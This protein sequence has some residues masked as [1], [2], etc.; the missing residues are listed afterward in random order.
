VIVA[1]TL[2]DAKIQAYLA[3]KEVVV[4]ATLNPD[5]SPLAMPMWFLHD[6]TGLTMLSVDGLQKVKNLRRDGR[7]AV[8]AESGTRADIRGVS[9]RGRVE[10]LGDT[11]ERAR[12]VERFHA[13]YQ[14]DLERLWR[15][16][17]MPGNRVMFR[18]VP[19]HV[20]AWGLG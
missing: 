14:P 11:P 4:L 2:D 6:A 5:G 19:A 18:I 9:V 8:V 3:T 17:Q 10:F 13:K 20:R 7:V 12:L 1:M 16:R 15:G